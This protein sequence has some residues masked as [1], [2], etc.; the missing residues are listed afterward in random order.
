MVKKPKVG[1]DEYED[2]PQEVSEEIS[3]LIRGVGYFFLIFS[4][5]MILKALIPTDFQNIQWRFEVVGQIV[6]QI[7]WI[8]LG[9][10]MVFF[11]REGSEVSY[12]QSSLLNF[13][14]WL[15]LVLAILY[16]VLV[17]LAIYDTS[18]MVYLSTRDQTIKNDFIETKVEE[19]DKKITQSYSVKELQ[20]IA[21]SIDYHKLN[22]TVKDVGQLKEDLK[23]PLQKFHQKL[24]QDNEQEHSKNSTQ[25]FK[26]AVN[27]IIGSI[28]SGTSLILLW[29]KALWARLLFENYQREN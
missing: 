19:I 4:L 6:D 22:L 27:N 25:F 3:S 11:Y 8:L 12:Q 10:A 28:L 17:P 7:W 14:Y 29:R 1:F 2:I 20:E 5:L 13:F 9:L 23:L 24:K 16:F 18:S 21:Q 26:R 15:S